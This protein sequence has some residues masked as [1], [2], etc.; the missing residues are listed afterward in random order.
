MGS[1]PPERFTAKWKRLPSLHS[2]P[3]STKILNPERKSK[4]ASSRTIKR[5]SPHPQLE[6]ANGD[7]DKPLKESWASVPHMSNSWAPSE[8]CWWLTAFCLIFPLLLFLLLLL[9]SY[10]RAL[11]NCSRRDPIHSLPHQWLWNKWVKLPLWDREGNG[12]P[13]QYSCL[14][15]RMDGGAW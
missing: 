12:T 15:N 2:N 11:L 13:L 4:M 10:S 14:E 5:R 1:F 8:T 7:G 6:R 9:L 3:T